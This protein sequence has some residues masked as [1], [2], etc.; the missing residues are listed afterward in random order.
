M[1]VHVNDQAFATYPRVRRMFHC[2]EKVCRLLIALQPEDASALK[3]SSFE[4]ARLAELRQVLEG[5]LRSNDDDEGGDAAPAAGA[6]RAREGSG[7]EA[8]ARETRAPRER[9]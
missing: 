8:A 3:V 2:G 7:D 6:K 5:A 1:Q 4:A 9:A